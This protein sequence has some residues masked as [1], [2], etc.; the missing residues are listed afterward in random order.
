MKVPKPEQVGQITAT[1]IENQAPDQRVS[2]GEKFFAPTRNFIF[3]IE[4][5]K[6]LA[7]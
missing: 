3:F 6:I 4:T 5:E 2:T 1:G 7:R